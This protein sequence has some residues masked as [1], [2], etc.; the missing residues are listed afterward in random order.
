KT[1]RFLLHWWGRSE[2][3]T[4]RRGPTTR[5]MGGSGSLAGLKATDGLGLGIVGLEDRQELGDGEQGLDLL[6]KVDQLE[7]AALAA[8]GGVAA[9]DLAQ[10]SRVD[11]GDFRQ[12][13]QDLRLAGIHQLRD[14][15]AEGVVTL[16]DEDL[17]MQIQNDDV[18]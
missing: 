5:V 10:A 4:A 14:G 12:V 2:T 16:A 8:D 9:H 18:I 6:G 7:T 15:I 1:T 13:Q 3:T 17:S 11:V